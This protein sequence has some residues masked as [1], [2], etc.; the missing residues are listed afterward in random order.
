MGPSKDSCLKELD[1]I[2]LRKSKVL[3]MAQGGHQLYIQSGCP[4]TRKT[5]AGTVQGPGIQLEEADVIY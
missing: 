4:L 5:M 2:P 1:K 3:P